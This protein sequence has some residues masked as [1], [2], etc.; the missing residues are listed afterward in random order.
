MLPRRAFWF[1][2]LA[3]TT[4]LCACQAEVV[5]AC[6][7]RDYPAVPAGASTVVHVSN[8]C[9]AG[10]LED[11]SAA[12]PY[13][14]IRAAIEKA[15][16][17]AAIVI[18]SGT[19]AEHL[20]IDK[21][22]TLIGSSDPTDADAA[23][24]E[25]APSDEPFTSC[26]DQPTKTAIFVCGEHDV[27]IR[28]LHVNGARAAGIAAKAS[29]L[30][31]EGSRIADT[32]KEDDKYGYGVLGSGGA[33]I[34]L[35]GSEVTGS[36]AVG[37]LVSDATAS[38]RQNRIHDNLGAGVWLSRATETVDV[39]ENDIEANARFGVA[40][41]GSNAVLTQ[42]RIQGTAE[43]LNEPSTGYG[44]I[45]AD[46]PATDGGANLPYGIELTKN[47]VSDNASCGVVLARNT[48]GFIVRA[49]RVDNN[50]LAGRL[51]GGVLLPQGAVDGAGNL[52]EDNEITGNRFL[53]IGIA[54]ETATIV[55]KGNLV[56]QTVLG[57]L[58]DG[59]GRTVSIGDG[60]TFSTRAA[61]RLVDNI[62]RTNER[63][64]LILNSA[65]GE[66]TLV[67]N[68][69]FEANGSFGVVA[70]DLR[71]APK[72]SNNVYRD[73]ADGDVTTGPKDM[74]GAWSGD[75]TP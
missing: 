4:L 7:P 23:G 62:V 18:M 33:V 10:E 44:V 51:G 52:I 71:A 53:G 55:V 48:L 58:F 66:R 29:R 1:G 45:G 34:V 21:D 16:P 32:A 61:A 73:N 74:F 41:F 27:T 49:N 15:E 37:V 12:R 42:N 46:L 56:A 50:G 38:L 2:F 30:T 31:I 57:T 26:T 72:L 59:S 47:D 8:R 5:V 75:A 60:I 39:I 13:T 63:F 64:G 68:N 22:L 25:I 35:Q 65:D 54:G 28:G 40:V 69:I 14:T 20:K 67:E 11:G 9:S 19:Y 36:A 3:S 17:G 6:R 43:V 70:Q 24:V